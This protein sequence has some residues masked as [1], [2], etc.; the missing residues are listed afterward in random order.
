MSTSFSLLDPR[1][2]HE[3]HAYLSRACDTER[4]SVRLIGDSGALAVY[5]AVLR[6]TGLRDATPTV[7]GLRSF[8]VA[9]CAPFDAVVPSRSL[10]GRLDRARRSVPEPGTPE[11]S[12]VTVELPLQVGTLTWSQIA[13]PR[14]RWRRVGQ[15]TTG[16]LAAAAASGLAEIAAAGRDVRAEVWGRPL[17]GLEYVPAGAALAAR[18]LG[19]L[20]GARPV[21]VLETGRWTRLASGPGHVL[22]RRDSWSLLR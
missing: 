11:P 10:L 20:E 15:T 2:A 19:L 7:L 21:P 1:A 4:A 13:L 8:A 3:I 6:P 22:V 12:P 16:M 17:A 14:G 18:T 5:T 9:P